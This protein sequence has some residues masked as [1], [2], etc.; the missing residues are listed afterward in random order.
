MRN[1]ITMHE[2]FERLASGGKSQPKDDFILTGFKSCD[3][4]SADNLLSL[5]DAMKILRQVFHCPG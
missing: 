1:E 3:V 5:E 2:T 4:P